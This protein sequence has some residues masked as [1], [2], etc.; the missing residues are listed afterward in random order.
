[1]TREILL[2]QIAL[3]VLSGAF[4]IGIGFLLL[5]LTHKSPRIRMNKVK[6]KISSSS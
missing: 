5:K 1:M 3:Q 6:D 4:G 2:L